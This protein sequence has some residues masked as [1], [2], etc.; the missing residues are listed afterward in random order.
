MWMHGWPSEVKM[1]E[2]LFGLLVGFIIGVGAVFAYV[3]WRLSKI[4]CL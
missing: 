4:R 3:V 1:T 2:F